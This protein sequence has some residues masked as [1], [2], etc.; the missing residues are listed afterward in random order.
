MA[1]L[2]MFGAPPDSFWPAGP[3]TLVLEPPAFLYALAA[4]YRA[5]KSYR[6][7]PPG[8]DRVALLHRIKTNL[9][10]GLPAVFGFY[11]FASIAAAARTGEVPV[12]GPSDQGIGGHAVVAVGY[13]DARVIAGANGEPGT[14]G[15]LRIRSSWGAAWGDGGYGWLPYDYV[16]RELA[17]DWWSLVSAE[18]ASLE[19]PTLR[20]SNSPSDKPGENLK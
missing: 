7:D 12:P 2:V 1:A 13:D 8:V 3:A 9:A 6:Y 11:L 19:N 14:T 15:A 5:L 18:W 10:A 4:N 20:M 16:L 17:H